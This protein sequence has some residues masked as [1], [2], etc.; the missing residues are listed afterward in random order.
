LRNIINIHGHIHEAG[1]K[2]VRYPAGIAINVAAVT[3]YSNPRGVNAGILTLT[4]TKV[5]YKELRSP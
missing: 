4:S 3:D 5:T 1:G 2:F